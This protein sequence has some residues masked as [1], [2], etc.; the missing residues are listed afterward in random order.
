MVLNFPHP[1]M[2][3]CRPPLTKP[4]AGIVNKTPNGGDSAVLV[5]AK[6]PIAGVTNHAPSSKRH[7][8]SKQHGTSYRPPTTCHSDFHS[9]LHM[10]TDPLLDDHTI[11]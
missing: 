10:E 7:G 9:I 11:N 2:E 8:T 5:W 4:S 6:G 3:Y 1:C